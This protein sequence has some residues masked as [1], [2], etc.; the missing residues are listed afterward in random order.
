[1][2]QPQLP[3]NLQNLVQSIQEPVTSDQLDMYAKWQ[4]VS[5]KSYKLRT[6]VKAW[7]GQ[8]A[9]ER[10]MRK[11]FAIAIIIALFAQII[12]INVAFCLIGFQKIEVSEWVANVF[13]V[14]VFT[15]I[16]SMTLLVLRY[17]FPKIGSEVMN[18]IKDL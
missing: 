7:E 16:V 11:G 10:R 14:S 12:F 8:N 9:E 18:L 3:P 4:D 6:I 15:E 1:M 17:L 13:V 2:S 5:D